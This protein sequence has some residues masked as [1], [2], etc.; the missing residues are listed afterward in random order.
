MPSSG[1]T[2]VRADSPRR[3]DPDG[4]VGAVTQE[5]PPLD[6]YRLLRAPCR[7]LRHRAGPRPLGRHV[8][9]SSR[10]RR[11]RRRAGD[12]AR[13]QRHRARHRRGARRRQRR[14][15]A[16]RAGHR[17][18]RH[19]PRRRLRAGDRSVVISFTGILNDKLR[20]FYRSTFRDAAGT[21][22][23]IATTQMQATDCR[24]AFPCWDEPD[25]KAVFGITLVIDPRAAGRVQRA[26]GRAHRA[27]RWQ[28]RRAVR[29]HDGDEH[30][31]RRLRRRAARGHRGGRR[32]RH[33]AARRAR[34]RQG[35]PDRFRPRRRSVLPALVPD[36]LRHPVPGRQGRSSAFPDF[37]AGA[38]ENLGCITFRENALLVD[39]ATATM[40]EQMRRRRRRPRAG[41]HVVRRSRHDAL[42][43]RHLAER[44]V[45]HVH[46]AD[47]VRRLPPGLGRWTLFGLERSAAFETDSL[48]STRPVEFGPL[49]QGLRGMF[50][51][52]TYQKGGALLRMLEQYLGPE[53]FREGVSTTRPPPPTA[54]P[55]RTTSGTPSRTTRR[56]RAADDG[57]VDLAAGLPARQR[58]RRRRRARAAPGALRPR[59]R[60]RSRPTPARPRGS[61]RCTCAPAARS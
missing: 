11:R 20:G 2:V 55:R 31:P 59:H 14:A 25:F 51:V 42:V 43:E 13:A 27:T 53:R 7:A 24:R 49:A 37:A 8:R 57:L 36:L 40:D 15:V 33:P 45:R 23:V 9:R 35:Q 61:C 29:R 48:A 3:R 58:I 1:P 21:E 18:P 6:P 34:P 16:P 17:A 28:G 5:S 50:D 22:Q 32:R 30:V 38:M 12:G 44:G 41:P 47:L 10:H 39:P 4:T 26:R 46:G 54:T 19:Q 56:A 52:L 60:A